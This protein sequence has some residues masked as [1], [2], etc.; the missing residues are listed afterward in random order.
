MPLLNGIFSEVGDDDLLRLLTGL[1]GT[2][3]K[4]YE[5]KWDLSESNVIVWGVSNDEGIAWP[6]RALVVQQLGRAYEAIEQYINVDFQFGGVF[7]NPILAAEAEVDLVAYPTAYDPADPYG[8]IAA[9]PVGPAS[10][11]FADYV[12][13]QGDFMVMLRPD[14]STSDFTLGSEGFTVLLHEIGHTLGLERI[15]FNQFCILRP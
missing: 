7:D 12:G 9:F 15:A 6:D 2:D 11:E 10:P 13:V 8:G 3:Q 5:I 1:S 14:G 4:L